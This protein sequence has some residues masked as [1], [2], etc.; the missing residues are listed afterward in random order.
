MENPYDGE[1]LTL[2]RV[3]GKER[4]QKKKQMLEEWAD[5]VL[6]SYGLYNK[7]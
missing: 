5:A 4:E 6:V 1:D 7:L 2:R 3:T